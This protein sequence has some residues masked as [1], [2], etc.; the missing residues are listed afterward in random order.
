MR[1]AVARKRPSVVSQESAFLGFFSSVFIASSRPDH[2]VELLY[3]TFYYNVSGANA[4]R[5]FFHRRASQ[6]TSDRW[7]TYGTQ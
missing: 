6:R 7:G 5:I 4:V 2:T 3:F 1:K